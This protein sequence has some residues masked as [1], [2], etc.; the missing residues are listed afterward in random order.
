MTV[1]EVVLFHHA[2]GIT[3]GL[4]GLAEELR[5]AGHVVLVPDLFEGRTFERAEDGVAYAGEVGFGNLIARG[6][7]A[8]SRP[9][10]R[11]PSSA[12]AGRLAFRCRSTATVCYLRNL[13]GST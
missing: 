2:L 9:A 12:R 1:A 10:S 4:L 8:S 13:L 7:E 5:R 3:P 11:S 6:G